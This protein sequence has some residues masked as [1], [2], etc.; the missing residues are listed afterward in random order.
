M[1]EL[2]LNQFSKTKKR[3]WIQLAEKQLK[4]ADPLTSLSW[5]SDGKFS[6]APYYDQS[7]LEEL[8][9]LE[10]FFDS[11]S[12]IDWKL[13]TQIDCKDEKS[14]NTHAL[15]AL[16][17]GCDGVV[18]QVH[19]HIDLNILL[20][21][22][23][24]DICDVSFLSTIP[25]DSLSQN[26]TGFL[27]SEQQSNAIQVSQKSEV[28]KIIT[29]LKNLSSEQHILRPS[30]TDF[31]LEIASIRALRFLISHHSK[32]DPWSIQIHSTVPLHEHA[33]KQWFLNSTAGLSSI[34]GGS[35]SITF[36]TAKGNQRTSRN[37]GNIIRA[38]AGI[39]QYQ[40]QCGGSFYVEMLT[41]LII[42][43]CNKQLAK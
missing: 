27:I 5:E 22:I 7:D 3:E 17:G 25:F 26:V 29:I 23:I 8:S 4:G 19:S 16:Q 42:E 40:D 28:N 43:E 31:F 15:D 38:E 39:T 6:L 41:H 10:K 12:P 24:T 33:D 11:V 9:Y 18:F 32:I 34:L 1:K 13:Y 21:G 2:N 14:A 20:N 30:S 35:N 36:Q 37:V